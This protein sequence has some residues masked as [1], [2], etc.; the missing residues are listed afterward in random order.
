MLIVERHGLTI[1]SDKGSEKWRRDVIGYIFADFRTQTYYWYR[2]FSNT[3]RIIKATRECD[4][5]KGG[6]GWCLFN[7]EPRQPDKS[8]PLTDTVLDGIK[9]HR[10]LG[11]F[12]NNGD[13]GLIETMYYVSEAERPLPY[14]GKTVVNGKRF[15]F[16]RLDNFSVASKLRDY[17]TMEI[18][19]RNLTK[20]ELKVF[21][22]W[23]RNAAKKPVPK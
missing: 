2:H 9:C 3:A 6:S 22:A 20:K 16:I 21:A 18:T 10:Q 4:T 15:S 1:E 12:L 8:I 7:S 23:K 13:T 19:S 5:K 14:Y 17:S 11:Y